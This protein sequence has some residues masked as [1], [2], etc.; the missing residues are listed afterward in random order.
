VNLAN[1]RLEELIL[2]LAT[3][4]LAPKLALFRMKTQEI[5]IY[6]YTAFIYIA[7]AYM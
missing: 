7:T 2:P 3:A 6:S 4:V 1:L 5:R